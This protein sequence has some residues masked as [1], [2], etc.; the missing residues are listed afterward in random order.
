MISQNGIFATRRAHRT[1]VTKISVD[2]EFF[3]FI[4]INKKIPLVK[5]HPFLV[6]DREGDRTSP[7]SY[8]VQQKKLSMIEQ[9][10]FNV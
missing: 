5:S 7:R 6:F 8:I 10:T 3:Y 9:L 4:H 1:L 2:Q